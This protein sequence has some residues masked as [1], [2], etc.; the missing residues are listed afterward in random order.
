MMKKSKK[1]KLK[2]FPIILILLIIIIIAITVW[3]I[4]F[5]PKPLTVT[6]VKQIE[7]YDYNL[8]SNETRVYK[9]YYKQLE[10]ELIDNKVDEKNYV[11]LISKLFVIDFYTLTNKL[12]NQDI[13]GVQF[14]HPNL[15][16]NFKN[17]ASS[18][19][20]KYVKNNILG[21]RKQKLPEVKSVEI[22]ESKQ[23]NYTKKNYS[24]KSAYQVTVKVDYVKDLE[25]PV[26]VN[27]TLIHDNNKLVIVELK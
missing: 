21:N 4:Y 8:E 23:I 9:K 5:K 15:Q 22:I 1:K 25:Y 24:D 10:E 14:I 7:D 3:Y 16:E 20:Y 26:E 19:I 11:E 13:G 18:T 12:T 2:I 6:V 27:L 17:E